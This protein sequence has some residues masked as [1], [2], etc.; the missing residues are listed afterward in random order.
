[1]QEDLP[2][3]LT[4]TLP[5]VDFKGLNS[6]NPPSLILPPPSQQG[7]SLSTSWEE[8]LSRRV[9]STVPRPISIEDLSTPLQ[10]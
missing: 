2:P 10:L 4:W 9:G 6:T 1:M 5:K 7:G 8:P 3:L